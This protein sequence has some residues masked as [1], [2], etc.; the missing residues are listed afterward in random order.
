M[1]RKIEILFSD[2]SLG[3]EEYGFIPRS[4]YGPDVEDMAYQRHLRK[5]FPEMAEAKVRD[6]YIFVP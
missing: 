6:G 2:I 4:G 5:N 3:T 1:A